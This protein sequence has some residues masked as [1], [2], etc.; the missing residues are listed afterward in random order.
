MTLF[1]SRQPIFDASENLVAYDLSYL[2]PDD[3]VPDD[4]ESALAAERMLL[5]ACFVQGIDRVA[6]GRPA[7]LPVSRSV[8]LRGSVRVVHPHRAVLSLVPGTVVDAELVATCQ[9]LAKDGYKIAAQATDAIRSPAFMRTVH[10]LR[11]DV[12]QLPAGSVARVAAGLGAHGARLLATGVHNRSVRDQC[13]EAGVELFHGYRL[14]RP[15]VL[16][17]RDVGI[18]H[19]A[20]FRLMKSIR[21]TSLP[22]GALEEGFRRDVALTYKLLRL[23]NAA[24]M[25]GRDIHTIGHAIRLL[26][27]ETLYRWLSLLLVSG[28]GER[29][30]GREL[31]HLSLTR[32]RF[33]EWVADACGIRKAGE[34]LFMVGLFSM[35]D[36]L[37][38]V[39]MEE[40]VTRLEL[41]PDVA[42]ALTRRADFYGEVLALSEAYETGD[43][44]TV[45]SLCA[46]LGLQPSTLPPLYVDAIGWARTQLADSVQRDQ[47]NA[48][49]RKV[50]GTA[51][52]LSARAS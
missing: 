26:G 41:A 31:A 44:A 23:V 51:K 49:L 42:A 24:S 47:K 52:A 7:F 29:G 17:R 9:L 16:P 34:S 37:L 48:V 20:A 13:F 43:W 8:V 38:L 27:R 25:G 40:L 15:E 22:D 21:D 46:G 12:S 19:V 6:E 4:V 28:A 10:L 33:C 2:A 11:L 5:E 50:S 36:T 3:A 45:Q 35:L 1:L 39:D 14:T 32:A 30:V 18:D